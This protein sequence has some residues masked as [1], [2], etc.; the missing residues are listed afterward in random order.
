MPL[1]KIVEEVKAHSSNWIKRQGDVY[2]GFYWQ[3]GYGA[4][5]VN[6]SDVE[7]V[8]EYIGNQVEHH[9]RMAFE[10][11]YRGFLKK[12]HVEFDERYVWD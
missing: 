6:P 1:V 4:F 2:R 3:N 9:K 5:S 11:E 12:Y 10:E 7:V 8:T